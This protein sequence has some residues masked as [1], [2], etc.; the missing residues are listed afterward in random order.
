VPLPYN[1]RTCY[2]GDVGSH[3][4]GQTVLLTGWVHNRRD[5]GGMVFIDLRDRAGV[6]QLKFSPATDPKSHEIAAKLRNEYCIAVRGKVARR[7]EGLVNPR[8]K[9]G[10]VEVQVHAIDILSPSEP[11]KF[12]IVDAAEASEELR[13]RYRYLDLRRRPLQESLVTRHR[14]TKA[15]RD[16]FDRE[17]FFEIETPF[18]TKSTPEGAR[19]YLVPSRIQ[20]G[21][22]YALPQ[23]PQ[24]FKQL[25]M[26]SGFDRYMQ[27]VRCFRDEDLRADRQPEFTQLDVEM[28]FVQPDDVL[29]VIEG[30]LSHVMKVIHNVAV[31]TPFPRMTYQQALD[32]YGIDRPDTRYDLRIKDVTDIAR[33]TEF[34]VFTNA[35]DDGGVVRC[36]RVPGGAAMTRKETDTLADDLRGIG[37]GGLPLVKVVAGREA[38]PEFQSGSA[39]YFTPETTAEMIAA[40]QAEAGDI[41]FFAADGVANVCKYLSWLREVVAERRGLIPPGKWNF[42]WVLDFP[43]FEYNEEDGRYYAVHHPFTAPRD[44]DLPLLETDPAKIRA[45]A[46]DVVLNGVELGGG[47]IR[48]HRGDVQEKVFKIL[49]L[50]PEEQQLKFG[51]LLE[52]LKYGPPPHGGIALGLDRIAMLLAGLDNIRDTI[53]FPKTARA[54]CPLT[55]APAPVSQQ[56]LAELGLQPA[57]PQS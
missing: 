10:E 44:E 12:E 36:I 20:P 3:L 50:T 7:P 21:A 39:K 54:V 57:K 9:T 34:R 42:L 30:C 43:L 28:S 18:L 46:Y 41:L 48:I 1:Q 45:K 51:F 55:A 15:I 32:D 53:A 26:M 5:H 17:G 19:D 33:K 49:K 22:F 31:E 40:T 38:R 14:I 13:L 52:A 29:H 24:L 16:Y 4:I 37:A 25:L 6:V 11:P 8:M 23:S 35:V 27:I 56:Q 47:S 2:C